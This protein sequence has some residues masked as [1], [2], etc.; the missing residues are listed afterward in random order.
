MKKILFFLISIGISASLFADYNGLPEARELASQGIIVDQSTTA[1]QYRINTSLD[2]QESA[3]Y[4]LSDLIIRQEVL[5]IALKLK[6]VE[7]PN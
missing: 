1:Q 7:L 6:G 3:M 4:R 2:A 5:G